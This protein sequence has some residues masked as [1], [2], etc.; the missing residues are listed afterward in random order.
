M[1]FPRP[2]TK[3]SIMSGAWRTFSEPRPSGSR[4]VV[5]PR[6]TWFA[7]VLCCTAGAAAAAQPVVVSSTLERIAAVPGEAS[8]TAVQITTATVAS[9]AD[10]LIVSVK[11]ANTS[12]AVVDSVR[13]TSPIPADVQ[14][15]PGSASGPGSEVLFSVDNG[16]TFGRS[17]ELTVAGPSGGARA[18]SAADYTHVRW[19]LH[20][21]LDAGA[22]GVARFRAVPR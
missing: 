16:R 19:V 14:F 20:A 1:V 12:A 17:D 10:Q 8:P 13:V 7:A 4:C 3:I 21:P 2:R 5:V 9:H 22:T 15:V 6:V 11:F 18:A